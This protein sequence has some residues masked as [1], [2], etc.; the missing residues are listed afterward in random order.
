M[1]TVPARRLLC[2]PLILL[3]A[4]LA[5]CAPYL[6]GNPLGY[7]YGN[8]Y[9]AASQHYGEGYYRT[10]NY[11]FYSNPPYYHQHRHE[12]GEERGEDRD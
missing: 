8:P 1:S 6:P 10:P 2:V 7:N 12:H 4:G 5:G 11:R 3:A 9:Y